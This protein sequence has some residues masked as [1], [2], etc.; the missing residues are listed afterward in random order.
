MNDSQLFEFFISKGDVS[1]LSEADLN[2]LEQILSAVDA[3][4]QPNTPPEM[5]TRPGAPARPAGPADIGSIV[6]PKDFVEWLGSTVTNAM[7][8]ATGALGPASVPIRAGATGALG[9]ISGAINPREGENRLQ[10]AVREG[11]S[12]A[13]LEGIFG[14]LSKAL[15]YVGNRAAI[16]LGSPL[17]GKEARE[18]TEAFL[19]ERQRGGWGTTP[20][21]GQTTT[22]LRSLTKRPGLKDELNQ[23]M[24]VVKSKLPE[25]VTPFSDVRERAVQNNELRDPEK[26]LGVDAPV[27][28]AG[29]IAASD[30]AFWNQNE[31]LLGHM[32]SLRGGPN[33]EGAFG[34]MAP[35]D[36]AR[37]LPPP[38][39][40]LPGEV[41]YFRVGPQAR[42]NVNFGELVEMAQKQGRSAA[43]TYEKT[44]AGEW[45]RVSD[46]PEKLAARER[47][48]ILKDAA[49]DTARSQP[50]GDEV[51][52]T[53]LNLNERLSDAF[54]IEDVAD[55]IRRGLAFAGIR[56]G[57]GSGLGSNLGRIASGAT[58]GGAAGGLEGAAAGGIA[59]LMLTPSNI[60]RF[61]NVGG[62]MSQMAPSAWRIY[63]LG[64]QVS[65]P[66]IRPTRLREP[67]DRNNSR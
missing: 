28:S 40:T 34:P 1:T 10:G 23:K 55:S 64:Q 30:A 36:A 42:P 2:R 58:A 45:V 57:L 59:G 18:A 63:Q 16:W 50:G 43:A 52:D 35:V 49:V 66:P 21:V 44:N 46:T 31:E 48:R 39:N 53:Y 56:G 22:K 9:A 51:A 32:Q 25:R 11:A 5:L 3:A 54:S 7:T 15:P 38:G 67:N 47:N 29:K 26:F 65:N 41:P 20:A 37:T 19:R 6:D 24:D 33:V 27:D 17:R 13:G 12:Q 60:S 61:G 62:R 4:G 14:S 8:F